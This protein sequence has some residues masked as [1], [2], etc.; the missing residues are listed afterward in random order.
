MLLKIV[1]KRRRL[2]LYTDD[3]FLEGNL[4]YYK[5]NFAKQIRLRSIMTDNEM[6]VIQSD[7]P[8]FTCRENNCQQCFDTLAQ[9]LSIFIN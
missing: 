8:I 3:F 1:E 4:E 5:R 7:K 6:V 2:D 9:V